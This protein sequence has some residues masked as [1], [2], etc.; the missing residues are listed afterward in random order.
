MYFDKHTMLLA[1]FSSTAPSSSNQ[2]VLIETFYYEYKETGGARLSFNQ[3]TF[4]NG[5]KHGEIT[6]SEIRPVDSLPK[7]IFSEPK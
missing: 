6:R 1:K 7:S 2:P 5:K 3:S 4:A